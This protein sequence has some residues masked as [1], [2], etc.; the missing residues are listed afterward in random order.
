MT[1]PQLPEPVVPV[2][3]FRRCPTGGTAYLRPSTEDTVTELRDRIDCALLDNADELRDGDTIVISSAKAAGIA[4]Q[5]LTV[6]VAEKNAEIR[7][8]NSLIEDMAKEMQAMAEQDT[9]RVPSPVEIE[10]FPKA[11]QRAHGTDLDGR[12]VVGELTGFF[13]WSHET[14]QNE[15]AH[16]TL[17]NGVQAVVHT[18]SL[19]R[20]EA[21]R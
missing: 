21:S 1:R 2:D 12:A 5:A 14:G 19:R 6:A 20:A 8:L 9:P 10:P 11:G 3:W 16:L 17:D 15:R 18:G 7:R 4:E 13:A